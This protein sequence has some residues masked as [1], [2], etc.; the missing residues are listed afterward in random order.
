MRIRKS[1]ADRFRT[2]MSGTAGMASIKVKQKYK[3]GSPSQLIY[4][5]NII[6]RHK[7]KYLR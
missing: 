2:G 6:V 3:Y 4:K 5:L 7:Y 1:A